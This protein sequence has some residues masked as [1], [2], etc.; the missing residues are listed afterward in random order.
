MPQERARR[1][2]TSE[3]PQRF[4]IICRARLFRAVPLNSCRARCRITATITSADTLF[5]GAMS[6]EHNHIIPVTTGTKRVTITALLAGESV[7]QFSRAAHNLNARDSL[8]PVCIDRGS[9]YRGAA[10][11]VSYEGVRSVITRCIDNGFA[12]SR[13]GQRLRSKMRLSP[14]LT[15][16]RYRVNDS[17]QIFLID[18]CRAGFAFR[19]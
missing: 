18:L 4:R 8:W 11:R 6:N 16:T 3:G 12:G 19:M 7:R 1:Q 17:G 14:R 15:T 13:N 10:Q 9:V 5:T 2:G